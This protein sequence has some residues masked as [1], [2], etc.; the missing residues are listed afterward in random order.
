[1]SFS[2]SRR[3][4]SSAR[5][6]V[7]TICAAERQQKHGVG[8]PLAMKILVLEGDGIG[9]EIC[10]ATVACLKDISERRKLG[11]EFETAEIGF[12]GL[13]APGRTTGRAGSGRARTA[14]VVTLGPV[15]PA[16]YPPAD[17]GGIN[18]SAHL[19]KGLDLYANVRPSRVRAGIPAMAKDMDLVV[20]R[21]NT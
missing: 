16:D 17:K 6:V 3:E 19:R 12:A 8:A 18:P 7:M 13:R 15:S 4:M 10:A 11:L 14:G 5:A 1:C 9:P 20:M 2:D 21:E